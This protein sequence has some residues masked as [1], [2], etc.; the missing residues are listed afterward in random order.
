MA[1]PIMVALKM[2]ICGSRGKCLKGLTIVMARA[3]TRAGE[4]G[5]VGATSEAFGSEEGD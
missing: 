5:W 2:V 1:L 4:E 3:L